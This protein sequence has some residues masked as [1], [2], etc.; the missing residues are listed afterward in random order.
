MPC[1]LRLDD[2]LGHCRHGRLGA[3]LAKVFARDGRPRIWA[4]AT[5]GAQILKVFF[6]AVA[7]R[8]WLGVASILLLAGCVSPKQIEKTKTDAS[9]YSQQQHARDV[10][11]RCMDDGA[12]PGTTAYLEC[13]L[14]LEKSTPQN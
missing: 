6:E 7:Q 4:A 5:D 14:R 1:V 3:G 11:E 13:Q 9:S 12:M 10:R 2:I 8:R